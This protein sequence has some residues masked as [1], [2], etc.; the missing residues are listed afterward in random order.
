[1]A[2]DAKAVL[3]AASTVVCSHLTGGTVGTTTA[4]KLK[5][6]GKAVVVK[7]GPNVSSCPSKPPPQ[8][9]VACQTVSVTK[10]VATKLKVGTEFVVLDT[11]AGTP[12][13]TPPASLKVT[14]NQTKLK[15]K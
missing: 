13:G 7:A 8:S 1:M 10:G 3:T 6:S 4:A 12:S 5:V 9:N 11:L 15:A 2:D 14:A